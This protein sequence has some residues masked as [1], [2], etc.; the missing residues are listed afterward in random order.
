VS[1]SIAS[2]RTPPFIVVE[3]IDGAG[4]TTQTARQKARLERLGHRVHTTRE[5][6]DNPIG[7][8]IR[9]ILRGEVAPRS[10]SSAPMMALLFAADRIDHDLSEIDVAQRA[11]AIVISDR[12]DLSSLAYQSAAHRPEVGASAGDIVDWIR[13]LNRHARRPDLTIVVDVPADVARARRIDRGGAEELYEAA[14]LQ[15]RLADTYLRAETLVPGDRLVHVD[16]VGDVDEVGARID[17]ALRP[18]IQAS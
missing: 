11:G 8:L 1:A 3:G 17:D 10:A 18:I 13:S 12:Y 5:P 14:E 2:H 6:S 9:R 15:A 16:G 4:T 7:V